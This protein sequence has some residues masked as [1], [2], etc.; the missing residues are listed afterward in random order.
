MTQKKPQSADELIEIL[1][2]PGNAIAR[3]KAASKLGRLGARRAAPALIAA[4]ED[5]H[6]LVRMLAAQSL[7]LLGVK[8][9]VAP[10]ARARANGIDRPYDVTFREAIARCKRGR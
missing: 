3:S 6:P 10:L 4:L 7:G 9:A 5:P 8:R 2:G 1:A